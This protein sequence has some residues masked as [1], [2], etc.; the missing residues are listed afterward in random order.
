MSDDAPLHARLL[1][2]RIVIGALIAGVTT[3]MLVA[4]FLQRDGGSFPVDQDPAFAHLLMMTLA[5]L[6]LALVIA[7]SAV[8]RIQTRKLRESPS[9]SV[10]SGQVDDLALFAPFQTLTLVSAAMAE[11][12]ALFATVIF[13]VTAE[14]AALVGVAI[15]LLAL[16]WMFPTAASFARFRNAVSDGSVVP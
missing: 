14:K 5:G 15:G 12:F 9:P 16:F 7:H 8:R 2:L 6:G 3:F 10:R 13:L 1:Q 4:M 11:G